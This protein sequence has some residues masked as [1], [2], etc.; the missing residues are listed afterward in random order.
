VNAAVL[1]PLPV[2]ADQRALQACDGSTPAADERRSQDT[3]SRRSARRE[4]TPSPSESSSP[5]VASAWN[6]WF[7][8]NE[9]HLRVVL[10]NYVA[11]YNADRPHRSLALQPPQP[12]AQPGTGD[13]RRAVAVSPS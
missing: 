4:P 11:D 1:R 7:I 12:V 9:R 13:G 5:S 3:S 8:L 6:T 2:H 10:G